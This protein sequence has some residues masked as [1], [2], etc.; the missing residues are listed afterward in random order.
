[1]YDCFNGHVCGVIL[2]KHQVLKVKAKL[3]LISSQYHTDTFSIHTVQS[4]G[5]CWGGLDSW[6]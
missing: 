1:M 5:K 2:H 4:D 3:I 6:A